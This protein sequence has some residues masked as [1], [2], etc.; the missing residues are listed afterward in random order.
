MLVLVASLA[1]HAEAARKPSPRENA[2]ATFAVTTPV[3]SA[4]ARVVIGVA[5]DVVLPRTIRRPADVLALPPREAGCVNAGAHIVAERAF[6]AM[7]GS[8]RA[9]RRGAGH[10]TPSPPRAP[11]EVRE[12]RISVEGLCDGWRAALDAADNALLAARESLPP[13]ELRSRRLALAKER[14]STIDLLKAIARARGESARYLHLLPSGEAKRLLGLPAAV[15]ACVFNLDGVLIGSA[16]LHAAAWTTTFDEFIHRRVDRT[17]GQFAPF[18]PRTDY[19]RYLHGTPRLAGVRAFLASRG[20]SL[21]EGEPSDAAGAETVHG[22]ANRK[23]Q[24]LRR[25]L[26]EGGVTA[27]EGSRVYLETAREA[28]I[29]TAVVSASANTAMILDR[30]GLAPLIE[31]YVDGNAMTTQD[32]RPKPSPDA[33]HAVCALLDVPPAH[34]AAFETTAAG[35]VAARAAGFAAVLGIDQFD[36]AQALRAAGATPVVPG[37]A[38]ILDERLAA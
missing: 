19:A 14:K 12:P 33:L 37:L 17:R 5:K 26:D 24:V 7:A 34:A 3:P 21:P 20:I 35:V 25:R 15:E 28:G 36:Q 18:E 23:N 29:R 27:Y 31:R 4:P 22:L 13:D 6:P 38:E 32:L 10:E 16:T 11:T 1:A 9:K 30:C 2:A 8:P